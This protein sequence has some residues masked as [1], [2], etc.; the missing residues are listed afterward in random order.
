MQEAVTKARGHIFLVTS[1]RENIFKETAAQGLLSLINNTKTRGDVVQARFVTIALESVDQ[2][3]ASTDIAVGLANICFTSEGVDQVYNCKKSVQALLILL[4]HCPKLEGKGSAAAVIARLY[5]RLN[6]NDDL[7]RQIDM[8]SACPHLIKY[9]ELDDKSQLKWFRDDKS[10]LCW[11]LK[12]LAAFATGRRGRQ[13]IHEERGQIPLVNYLK[14]KQV[15]NQVRESVCL[16]NSHK[17]SS[18]D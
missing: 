4:E 3:F 14:N 2:K 13:M 17:D 10:Q 8:T 1:L 12:A 18:A 16:P 9:L 6:R 7:Q 15:D 5:P 11:F